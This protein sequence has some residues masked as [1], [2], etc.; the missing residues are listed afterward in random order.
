MERKNINRG[1]KKLT[2]WIDAVELYV[3]VTEMFSKLPHHHMKVVSN[4]IDAAH[5]VSR[6]ISEGYCRRGLK[7]YLNF[8]NYSLGSCGEI[9]SCYFA[10]HKSG[11]ISEADFERLDS[12]H[13][14][15]ENALLKLIESL[16]KKMKDGDWQDS[17][18]NAPTFQQS[19][20]PFRR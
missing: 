15:V 9:H 8:L 16:Q 19:N 13:Y 17:F 7:E 4:S 20:I 5:S 2:V 11:Q 3:M 12:L 10:C 6:N 18:V 1:Y 14:K